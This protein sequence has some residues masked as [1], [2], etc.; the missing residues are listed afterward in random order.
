MPI[1][2]IM[3]QRF[4]DRAHSN[5]SPKPFTAIAFA[6]YDTFSHLHR[7]YKSSRPSVYAAVLLFLQEPQLSAE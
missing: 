3:N 2:M 6:V 1:S 5:A 4:F 7:R